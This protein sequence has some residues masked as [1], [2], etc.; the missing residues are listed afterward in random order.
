MRNVNRR[1]FLK[2]SMTTA[3]SAQPLHPATGA[4]DIIDTHVYLSHWPSRRITGD[5]TTEL[6]DLLRKQGVTQAWAG[7]FDSLLH[8]NTAYVN[9]WLAAQCGQQGANFLMPFGAIN[10]KLPDWEEDL[11][12]CHEEF[13][14]PGIRVHPNYHDYTLTDPAFLRLLQLAAERGLIVQIA[15]WME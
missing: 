13:R 9:S 15:A 8:K 5:E 4:R 14:M 11:R 2:G 12:R 7:S 3:I 1:D 6:V 10:P